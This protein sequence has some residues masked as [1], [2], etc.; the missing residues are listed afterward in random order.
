MNEA[1]K[2]HFQETAKNFRKT[3][4]EVIDGY[5]L[6][7]DVTGLGGLVSL[8]DMYQGFNVLRTLREKGFGEEI[9]KLADRAG[10]LKNGETEARTTKW[11]PRKEFEAL[12]TLLGK[13][14]YGGYYDFLQ[15]LKDVAS[16]TGAIYV[17][18][19]GEVQA[20]DLD[21]IKTIPEMVAMLIAWS[22]KLGDFIQKNP[23]LINQILEAE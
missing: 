17:L 2:K 6:L 18:E 13:L 15:C 11:L 1:E 16:N 8:V 12:D 19:G 10:R 23:Q 5:T 9:R 20:W 4:R 3:I 21:D 22:H 14:G 7:E